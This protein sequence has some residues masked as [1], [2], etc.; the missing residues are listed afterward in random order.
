VNTIEN[1]VSRVYLDTRRRHLLER[2]TNM[3]VIERKQC[4]S[5]SAEFATHVIGHRKP[6]SDEVDFLPYPVE[7]PRVL[8]DLYSDEEIEFR[9]R[10]TGPC[11]RNLCSHWIGS[12]SLGH[13]VADVSIDDKSDS[14][15][16]ISLVCRW[17]AENK[18]EVCRSCKSILNISM[19]G[20]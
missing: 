13:A 20:S 4:P 18:S 14:S 1:S 5:A 2:F 10:M 19:G 6:N 12:C 11:V 16:S 15:C 3:S 9:F 7:M 17:A 8:R